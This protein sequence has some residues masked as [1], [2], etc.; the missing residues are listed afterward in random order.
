[1][2]SFIMNCLRIAIK[3]SEKTLMNFKRTTV[4]FRYSEY[5]NGVFGTGSIPIAILPSYLVN[6]YNNQYIKMYICG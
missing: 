4:N 2:M 3:C 5:E 1:M 6:M